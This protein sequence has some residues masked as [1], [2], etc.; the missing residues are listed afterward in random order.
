MRFEILTM[1][2]VRNCCLG[3]L[4]CLVWWKFTDVSD[5]L[6]AAIIRASSVNFD[7]RNVPEDSHL[8]SENKLPVLRE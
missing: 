7:Q 6:V 4:R 8:Q 5:G 2:S 3:L 1:A